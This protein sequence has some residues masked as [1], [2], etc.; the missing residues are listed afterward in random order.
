MVSGFYR[1]VF[2]LDIDACGTNFIPEKWPNCYLCTK[3]SEW[4]CAVDV[5]SCAERGWGARGLG[6]LEAAKVSA[7]KPRVT[8]IITK[9]V[10]N[11]NRH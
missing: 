6:R 8:K 7:K 4:L 11:T 9:A 5:K 1:D 10:W 2:L 3:C